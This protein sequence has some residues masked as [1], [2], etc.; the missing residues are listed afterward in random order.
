MQSNWHTDDSHHSS[1][2]LL[3]PS[4]SASTS[5]PEENFIVTGEDLD[6]LTLEDN[7]LISDSDNFDPV[8][9]RRV[10]LEKE[11]EARNQA[12]FERLSPTSQQNYLFRKAAENRI[13]A[14]KKARLPDDAYMRD[15]HDVTGELMLS[16]DRKDKQLAKDLKA[17]VEVHDMTFWNEDSL[18]ESAKSRAKGDEEVERYILLAAEEKQPYVPVDL[19]G[20]AGKLEYAYRRASGDVRLWISIRQDEMAMYGS[21]SKKTDHE[22][23]KAAQRAVDAFK[24]L[25]RCYHLEYNFAIDLVT[26]RRKAGGGASSSNQH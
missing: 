24:A 3:A 2:T 7:S 8:R 26:E 11:K 15:F 4:L 19:S 23:K 25:Q 20:H 14:E 17:M 6:R 21:T 13:E 9:A 1:L 22:L 5:R 18:S 12:Y 16:N 10:R